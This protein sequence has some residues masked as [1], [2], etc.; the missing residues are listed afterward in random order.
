MKMTQYDKTGAKTNTTVT[1]SLFGAP[2]N[3]ALLSQ[4]VHVY[5]SNL[6]QGTSKTKTRSEVDVTHK[7]VYAQKG[8]GNA[9]HGSKN[10]PIFVGGGIAHGPTGMQNWSRDL[11]KKM[12]KSALITALSAQAGK[13]VIHDGI[14][15][16]SGKTAEAVKMLK[17]IITTK[18]ALIVLPERSE[19][20]ERSLRNIP[21]VTISTANIV[22]A[23]DIAKAHTIILSNATIRAL[24]ERLL[25]T[26][27]T[28]T[29]VAKQPVA[30]KSVKKAEP[31]KVT[32]KTKVEA[33]IA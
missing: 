22:N 7:K 14:L 33:K 15:T 4:V 17:D 2:V 11:S 8:T 31:K 6:R 20:V 1:D 13:T 27:E 5:R 12:K 32:K 23:F 9:R 19:L 24:E 29:A 16:V 26:A 30:E 3:K 25:V 10:A 21:N 18:S 28:K